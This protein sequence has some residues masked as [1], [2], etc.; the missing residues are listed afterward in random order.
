MLR[1]R[2]RG[3]CSSSSTSTTSRPSTTGSAIAAGDS[4]LVEVADRLQA[5]VR[6]GDTVARLGGDEFV[7]LAEDLDEPEAAARSLAE[8]I[9]LAMRAPVAVGERQLYTSVSIGIAQVEPD[10]DPEVCLAQADAAM[11]QAKRGGPARFEIFNTVIG[12]DNRRGASWPTSSG[13]PTSWASCRVH[14]QP[15]FKLGGDVVGMEALLRWRPSRARRG[16]RRSSSSRCSSTAARSCPSAVGCSRRPPASAGRGRT[17]GLPGAHHVG[18]R[19]GP[20]AAGPGF[21][22][23]VSDALRR[24]RL[25]PESLVL[26]VTESAL[27]I[28]IARIGAIMQKIR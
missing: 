27:V 7:V 18:Q 12:E 8:R 9:H 4:L 13:S 1:R 19:L 22:D 6:A 2:G 24:S 25:A 11:Y 5:L 26:E 23:D 21:F 3:R 16:A 20:P 17:Q 10:V 15:L 14:Y 28:D